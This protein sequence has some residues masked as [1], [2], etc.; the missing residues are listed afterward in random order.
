MFL[1][2]LKL[3]NF[4]NYD[5]CEIDFTGNKIILLGKNAQGKTNLLE[6]IYYLATLSSFRANNDSEVIKK[7]CNSAFLSAELIK[8]DTDIEISIA[9]NPPKQ[10]LIKVNGLKK[11]S[12]SQY[13]GHLAVVNFGVSDLLLLRGAP[14]DRRRWLD[15]AI[16]QIY[17]A[18]KDRL[19]KYNKIRTQRN[20]LLKEFKG[21]FHLNKVQKDTLSV[22]DEQISISGSNIIHL[23]QKYL[24][25]VQ[26]IANLKHKKISLEEE[27]LVLEYNST[28]TG[29]FNAR[30][31]EIINPEK[32]LES[33]QEAFKEKINEEI[34]RIQTVIGPHRDDVSF[35]I[36][37]IEAKSFASQGQQRTIVLALK[38][39]ELDFIENI[40]GESPVLLLDDVLAELD[41]TR[42]NY[43]LN[44]IKK[45]TQTIITT[46]DISGFNE[47][48]LEDVTVYNIESGKII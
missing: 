37:N 27:D 20:N 47:K 19:N 7:G 11:S 14:S 30:E 41:K 45:D 4:R 5:S 15:D 36:N 38:L 13:L 26:I 3:I 43:L 32:I 34:A 10:K 24:K 18:Y 6:S 40:I 33:Y 28:I 17:P 22:F 2:K 25:E 21:N 44:S 8:N 12:Y 31:S 16:S 48:F 35:Y 23:R 29:N 46:T 9:I 39:S 42:Q 1:K